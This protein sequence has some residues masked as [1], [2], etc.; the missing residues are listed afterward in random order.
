MS[1]DKEPGQ[2]PQ[3]RET[4]W[5][6]KSRIRALKLSNK[7]LEEAIVE[8]IKNK[9]A[10]TEE[11]LSEEEKEA[12]KKEILESFGKEMSEHRAT[13]SANNDEIKKLRMNKTG[14]KFF[15]FTPNTGMNR[16]QAREFRRSR[17]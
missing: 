6:R 2:I 5:D 4:I 15:E 17:K 10:V 16:R 7:Q 14:S 8:L 13:I 3:T 9:P 12:K 1:T 11:G